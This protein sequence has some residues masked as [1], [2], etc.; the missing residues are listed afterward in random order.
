MAPQLLRLHTSDAY[1]SGLQSVHPQLLLA[2]M[3][4]HIPTFTRVL[5]YTMKADYATTNRQIDLKKHTLPYNFS[6]VLC[7]DMAILNYN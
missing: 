6:P 1:F 4:I 5:C 3:D 2:N 7:S